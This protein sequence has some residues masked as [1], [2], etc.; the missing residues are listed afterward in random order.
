MY[1]AV[2]YDF[3][4]FSTKFLY[5]SILISLYALVYRKAVCGD[6]KTALLYYFV[7]TFS[8]ITTIN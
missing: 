7:A 6:S 8:L 5:L 2:L 1:L 3:H 4:F